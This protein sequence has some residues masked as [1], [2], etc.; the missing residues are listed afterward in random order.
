MS[1]SEALPEVSVVVP[2]FRDA[3]ILEGTCA[4]LLGALS[5][6]GRTFELVLVN[7]GSPDGTWEQI[8]SL[9]QRYPGVVTGVNLWRNFGQHMAISAGFEHSRGR[10]IVTIDSDLQESPSEIWRLLER[11]EQG[12]DI[13]SGIRVERSEG[14]SRSIP[15]RLIGAFIR[16]ATGTT[17]QDVGCMFR[18]YRRE[19]A[20]QFQAYPS[21]SKI[22]TAYVAWLGAR[23]AE[24]PIQHRVHAEKPASRYSLPKLLRMATDILTDYTQIP[25]H[26]ITIVGFGLFFLGMALTLFLLAYRIINGAGFG[27]TTVVALQFMFAGFQLGCIGVLGQYL[28]RVHSQVDGKPRYLVRDVLREP[29]PA[30][31]A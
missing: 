29:A 4:E 23:I 10:Y 26:L 12:Y 25:I 17:L 24:V 22:V 19:M 15:S 16:W 9:C 11:L 27:L 30:D 21:H 28:G 5:S 20:L 13:A 3:E 2:C 31:R 8:R 1:A 7:D 14:L 18:A 6:L